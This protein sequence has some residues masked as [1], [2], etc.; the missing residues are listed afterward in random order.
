VASCSVSGLGRCR[1]AG[2][3]DRVEGR[4]A[5]PAAIAVANAVGA[6]TGE[7]FTVMA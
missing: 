4:L 5:R 3:D 7:S 1:G 2:N 6:K